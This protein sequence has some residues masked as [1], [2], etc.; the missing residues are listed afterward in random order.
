MALRSSRLVTRCRCANYSSASGIGGCFRSN[1]MKRSVEA[2]GSGTKTPFRLVSMAQLAAEPFMNATSSVY[3]EEMYAAWSEDPSSVHKSWNSFFRSVQA[4]MQP[5]LAYTPPPTLVP[6]STTA[7]AAQPSMMQ[8]DEQCIIDH[9]NVQQLIKR[10]QARGRGHNNA[11]LDPLGI[12]QAYLDDTVPLELELQTYGFSEKDLDRHFILPGSTFIG[13][14]KRSMTLREI[15]ARLKDAYCNHI[16]IEF[17]HISNPER[18]NWIKERFETP[19]KLEMSP[20]EKKV[21]FKRLIRSTKFEEFLAKK[22]PAEKRFGL[23]GVEVLIPALKQIIDRSS[24][25]G[26]ECFVLGMP[27]R[28]RLNILANVCRQ[29]LEAIFTQ[30]STLEPEDEGSGDVKYHLGVCIDR[31]NQQ[32]QKNIRISVIANPSHLEAADPVVQGKTRA[33]QFY[34]GDHQGDKVMSILMHGDAAFCG[35]GIVYETFDLSGLPAYTCH[36]SIHIVVNNQIGFTT[37]P[38]FSRSMP[39]CTDVGKVVNAP[40]FHVNADDPEAVTAVCNAASEYRQKFK[41]DVVIDLV[42]YR[43][44]GHNEQDEPMFTQPLM[45]QRIRQLPSVLTKYTEKLVNE[46]VATD[47]YVQGE[48]QSY[49]KIMEDAYQKAQKEHFIRNRDWL[50]SPWD[51]SVMG[52]PYV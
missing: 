15:L 7:A 9:L 49:G 50:D 52:S 31:Y 35:Q 39:Y 41:K 25:L 26:V 29:P 36:G 18:H 13:G 2:S 11:D 19:Q 30:F 8:V 22:W 17:V 24:A 6:Q 4:G 43:R 44:H 28:G 42:C 34:R 51:K 3:I 38:R 27:H 48:M 23:E 5:G 37:D 40:I 32:S 10:Y 16:G 1:F 46:G 20:E 21:L 45:Y 14:D 12:N 47:E 33:E